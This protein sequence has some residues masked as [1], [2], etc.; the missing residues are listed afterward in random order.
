MDVKSRIYQN[1]LA[2]VLDYQPEDK[3]RLALIDFDGEELAV[4]R[5]SGWAL[6]R[7]EAGRLVELLSPSCADWPDAPLGASYGGAR[8]GAQTPYEA[9]VI[10]HVACW[11]ERHVRV[12]GTELWFGMCSSTQF[13]A[14]RPI[15]DG[16]LETLKMAANRLAELT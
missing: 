16:D 7:F 6:A 11:V 12:P 14:P 4:Y 2:T 1:P 8:A 15:L 10:R 9:A 13:C 3:M 5:G